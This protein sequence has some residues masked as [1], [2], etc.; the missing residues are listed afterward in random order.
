[1]NSFLLILLFWGLGKISL[2][3]IR[4]RRVAKR[5]PSEL[6]LTTDLQQAM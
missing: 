6:Y 5:V 1:M 4:G 3:G 2:Q